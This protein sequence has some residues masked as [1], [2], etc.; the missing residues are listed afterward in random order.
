MSTKNTCNNI[1]F[2]HKEYI[3]HQFK[4]ILYINYIILYKMIHT[5]KYCDYTTTKLPNYFRHQESD[6]HNINVL[7]I[8]HE[9]ELRLKEE[10]IKQ[11]EEEHKQQLVICL[12]YTS[13]GADDDL[14]V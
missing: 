12:L 7:N 1:R 10:E 6:K 3:R 2:E 8:K 11:K 4:N 5:C 14:A 9:E 13:D